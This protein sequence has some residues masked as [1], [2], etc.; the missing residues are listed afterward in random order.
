M[1]KLATRA[2]IVGRGGYYLLP[3]SK[4]HHQGELL[5]K[6]V[7]EALQDEGSLEVLASDKKG[8]L[9]RGRAWEREQRYQKE[10]GKKKR[11][12]KKSE[13]DEKEK[14]REITWKER[15]LVVQSR[16]LYE[17]QR[18]GLEQRLTNAETKLRQLTPPPKQGRRQFRE[19][20]PLQE[21]VEQILNQHQVPEFLEVTYHEE[22]IVRKNRAPQK[23]YRVRVRRREEVLEAYLPTLGWRLYVTNAPP[24]RLSMAEALTLYRG[25]V[26]TIERL[27]SRLKGRPLG[28]RPLYLRRDDR[29]KGLVRLLSIAL[30]VLTLLEFVVRRALEKEQATLTGLYPGSPKKA[31][32]RPTAE[33]LLEAFQEIYLIHI[34]VSGQKIQY[35]SPLS[36]LQNRILQL[37]KFS[38]TIY[39][40]LATSL[41]HPEPLPP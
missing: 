28:L 27:F 2:H 14:K 25:G 1:E 34:V 40:S 8:W 30:R 20:A 31:T 26:P 21:Q 7:R 6:Y 24:E 17:K 4:K 5:E 15:L 9:L 18:R 10:Q 35:I 19:L 32:A 16:T 11:K 22:T 38:S 3:L 33:R 37:L 39:T 12:K 36:P 41:A 13:K 23:H 29:I